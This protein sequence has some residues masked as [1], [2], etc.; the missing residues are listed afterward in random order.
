MEDIIIK[1]V[2]TRK[3][4]R[5]FIYLPAKIHRNE[6]DW[7]PPIYLDEWGLF[8]RKKNRSYLYADAILLLAYRNNKPAGRIMGLINNRYNSI[9]N[10]KHG[11]FCFMECFEDPE[12]VHLLLMKI[13]QWAREKG[14]EKIVGPLGF[15]D[16]DPQ[17]FQIEGFEYPGI[18]TTPTNSPYMPILLEREGYTKEVDLV[19]YLINM[20][21]EL[22]PLYTKVFEKIAKNGDFKIIEF[23]TRA[24]LKPYIIPVLEL[25][26]DTFADIYGFVPL[27]DREKEELAARYLPILDPE[28]VKL[29]K[30]KDELAGFVIGMPDISKGIISAKGK[31]FPFGVLKILKAM[32]ASK[33]LTLLLGGVKKHFRGQGIDVIMGVKMFNTCLLRK[34]ETIDS[35]LILE[36]NT[37]MRA[38]CERLDGKIIKRFRIYQ[39]TL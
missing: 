8:N 4:L 36:S 27:N 37:R 31:L 39:K 15:S 16:K 6:P 7:L 9:K 23:S 14:M 11:R 10:Q 24:E 32:K 25:M 18:I 20:P 22:P 13:E 26:N 5:E 35:H 38:E 29:V 33:K 34:P 17:G 28:F 1:E 12:V 19:N 2:L 21:G 3:Q 30:V